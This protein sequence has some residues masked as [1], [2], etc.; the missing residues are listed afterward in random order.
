MSAT[1]RDIAMTMHAHP[2]LL[3]TLGEA[4]EGMYGL[5]PHQQPKREKAKA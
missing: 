4:A 2:T 3:E 5:S 1:A